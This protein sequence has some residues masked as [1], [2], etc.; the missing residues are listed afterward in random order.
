MK[1]LIL[2]MFLFLFSCKEKD[3][4]IDLKYEVLNQLI[5]EDIMKRDKNDGENYVYNIQIKNVSFPE[6]KQIGNNFEELPP[7]LFM[8]INYD[9]DFLETD[10]LFYKT[11]AEGLQD[12]K[13][14]KSKLKKKIKVITSQE[15]ENIY[16]THF[17]NFW[18]E[19]DK[20]YPN[21]CIK[22]ISVPFFNKEKNICIVKV[23]ESCGSL[24]GGG[25]TGIYKKVNGTWIKIDSFDHWV[26]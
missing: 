16:K 26:S 14:E 12:F 8:M 5:T 22:T 25:F 1:Y 9:K 15:I 24:W 20:R 17:R 19:F 10:S 3:E 23:S 13:F 11:Q 18:I 21:T 4:T 2:I 7:G 6:N